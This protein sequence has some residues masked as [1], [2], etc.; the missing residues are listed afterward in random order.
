MLAVMDTGLMDSFGH[1]FMWAT[2]GHQDTML[3]QY[4]IGAFG[5]RAIIVMVMFMFMVMYTTGTGSVGTGETIIVTVITGRVVLITVGCSTR[6][7][8]SKADIQAR[9]RRQFTTLKSPIV[10]RKAPNPVFITPRELP[11]EQSALM[12]WVA[13]VVP[14]LIGFLQAAVRRSH[15]AITRLSGKLGLEKVKIRSG[16]LGVRAPVWITEAV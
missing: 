4:G 14:S 15:M 8:G 12:K 10:V 6:V 9:P 1:Q 3:A 11:P 13:E 5:N 7:L 16:S 2:V